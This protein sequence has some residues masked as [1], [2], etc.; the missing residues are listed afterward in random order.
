MA[1]EQKPAYAPRRVQDSGCLGGVVMIVG[2]LSLSWVTHLS[3]N[4]WILIAVALAAV[5]KFG[6]PLSGALRPKPETAVLRPASAHELQ[7]MRCERAAAP[8]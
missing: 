3:L 6:P 4:T 5:V 7:A 2:L 1:G 8:I